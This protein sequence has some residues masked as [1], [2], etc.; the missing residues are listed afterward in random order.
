MKF[1]KYLGNRKGRS[2]TF[3]DVDECIFRTFAKIK[4]IKDGKEINKLN[5]QE[6]NSYKLNDGESFGYGEFRSAKIFNETSI[7]IP[8]TVNRIK[9]MLKIIKETGSKSKIIFLTARADFDSKAT[10][11][12]TFEDHGINMDKK[13]VYVERAGNLETGSTEARKKK[14]IL[15]YLKTGLYRRVRLLDDYEPN[16]K[17]LLDI[18]DSL[19][20]EIR[21]KVRYTYKLNE[22]EN[23]IRFW[24]LWVDGNGDLKEYDKI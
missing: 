12:K 17:A 1:N 2:V 4:I 24:A 9:K 18:R 19:P 13:N 5:N 8:Q 6:Y 20:K 16:L 23:P 14:I 15:D 7:P 22:N 10:F 11:I 21:D 3:C